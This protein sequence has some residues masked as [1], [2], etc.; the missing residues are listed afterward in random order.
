MIGLIAVVITFLVVVVF[1]AF[2]M[3]A[4]VDLDIFFL[5]FSNVCR[6]VIGPG[7][8]DAVAGYDAAAIVTFLIIRLLFDVDTIAVINCLVDICLIGVLHLI[9]HIIQLL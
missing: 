3:I 5:D 7:I 6:R 2:V 8:V 9:T 1:I 4:V